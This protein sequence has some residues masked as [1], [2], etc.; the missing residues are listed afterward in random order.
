MK[1]INTLTFEEDGNLKLRV[2]LFYK[3]RRFVDILIDKTEF[4]ELDLLN[5]NTLKQ[6]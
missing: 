5:N 2:E 3:E 4:D 6:N 1:H